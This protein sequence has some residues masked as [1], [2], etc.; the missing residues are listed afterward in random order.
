MATGEYVWND[1]SSIPD[2][3][4]KGWN[5]GIISHTDE[6]A[7]APTET[8]VEVKSPKFGAAA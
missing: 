6:G 1:I 2:A 5:E 7:P 3:I 4:E 8:S